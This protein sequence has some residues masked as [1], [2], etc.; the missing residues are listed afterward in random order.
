[1]GKV[2]TLVRSALSPIEVNEKDVNRW[3]RALGIRSD[4]TDAIIL[5]KLEGS[6]EYL[7]LH[8]ELERRLL[9]ERRGRR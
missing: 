9:L 3:I 1:M 2:L 5:K 4:D 7:K 6:E 8:V